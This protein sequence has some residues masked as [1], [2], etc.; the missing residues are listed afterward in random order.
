MGSPTPPAARDF[1]LTANHPDLLKAFRLHRL[2]W[3]D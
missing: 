2:T 1:P 3:A